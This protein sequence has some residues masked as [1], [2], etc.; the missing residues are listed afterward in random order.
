M[1]KI[2][3]R[4]GDQVLKEY[5]LGAHALKIGRLPDNTVV[6]DNPAVSSHHARIIA[7]ADK[8]LETRQGSFQ[9]HRS[10]IRPLGCHCV[11][12]IGDGNDARLH[13]KFIALQTLRITL[14]VNH[15]VV[16]VHARQKI[17]HRGNLGH[18]LESFLRMRLHDLELFIGQRRGFLQNAIVDSDLADIV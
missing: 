17:S 6:I 10:L 3:L 8:T 15:F 4:F 2:V 12:C 7:R 9:I 18:D 16:H 5:A 14:A 11:K 13:R 1:A